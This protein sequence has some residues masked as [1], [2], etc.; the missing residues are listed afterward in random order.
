MF[1]SIFLKMLNREAASP[2]NAP[3]E[4]IESL[5]IKEGDVIADI[6]SGGGYF[7]LRFAIEVGKTGRVYAV[8]T[9]AEYLDFV[10]RMAERE[11]LD[12]V[13]PSLAEG[14]EMNLPE[15]ALDL[16]FARNVFHHLPD[17]AV[18]FRKAGRFLKPRGRIAIIEHAPAG[19]FSFVGMFRHYT[20]VEE[21]LRHM[22][23]AG[24]RLVES[25]DFL[26]GQSFN[27][28]ARAGEGEPPGGNGA[29]RNAGSGTE[30]R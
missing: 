25:Y 23:A 6:G 10:G 16:V 5:R 9:K 15:G 8:D 14:D 3:D 13:V 22:E 18:F 20:P 2:A 29:E 27:L 7:T 4:I 24:Y 19:G 1:T 26:P 12:N 11:G 28:F 30:R 17:P 21:I